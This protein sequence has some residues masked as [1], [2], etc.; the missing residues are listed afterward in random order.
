MAMTKITVATPALEW[1]TEDIAEI[2][3]RFLG[4][5]ADH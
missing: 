3:E 1:T 4:R 2:G 5:T